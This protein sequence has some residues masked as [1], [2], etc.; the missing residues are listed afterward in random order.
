[1]LSV[2]GENPRQT[3]QFVLKS[4]WSKWVRFDQTT[5]HI[6][7]SFPSPYNEVNI[8]TLISLS[9]TYP[10]AS[11]PQLQLLSRYIGAFGVDSTLFGSVLRTYLSVNGVEW[12][13]GAVCVFDGLQNV[14]D[15][16]VHWYE[17]HLSRQRAGELLREDTIESNLTAGLALRVTQPE[18]EVVHG[19]P[20]NSFPDSRE[21]NALPPGIEIFEAEPILDRKSSFVGRACAITDPSQV[22]TLKY[23]FYSIQSWYLV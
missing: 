20:G 3:I 18:L 16:C 7:N 4:Q 10:A 9:S 19:F 2:L 17:E 13:S 1:M 11:P 8:K 22:F 12:T 6:F 15:R 14:L 5:A 23:P 21:I